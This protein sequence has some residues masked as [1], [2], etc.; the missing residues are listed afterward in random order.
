VR[1]LIAPDKF[2]GTATAVEAAE[3][4]ALGAL[5][6]GWQPVTIPLADGG[7]GTL[8]AFGGATETSL[9]TGPLGRPVEA[10]WRLDGEV[11]VVEMAR[12][13]GLLLAGGAEHNDPLAATSRGTGELI[14]EAVHRG[15]RRVVVGVG[16]S[17]CTD[18]GQGAAEVLA[19][20]APLDGS[21]GHLV[22]VAYDVACRFLDAPQRFGPQKGATPAE[23]ELLTDRLRT[24]AGTYRTRY[25]VD[26]LDL[27][28]SGAAGGLGGGL[29]AL[30]A[31]LE[32]GFALIADAVGL[33]PAM[34]G[35]DLVLTGE[36]LLDAQSF[37]GKVVG[38]VAA[39]ADEAGLPWCA[40]VGQAAERPP[41]T[42]VTD[43]VA[44]FGREAALTS[45]AQCLRI[46]ARDLLQAH[47]DRLP[48][49]PAAPVRRVT[50]DSQAGD[51]S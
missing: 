19:D 6:A 22:Q 48:S 25:G 14:A 32:P 41:G 33:R 13:S 23:V 1:I 30:G 29:A 37:D 44:T 24:L 47:A 21:R 4:L 38:G 43:L 8:E 34:R 17:A 11:A 39:A 16:G 9:V 45:T 42:V 27:P 12:A 51:A 3:A 28:G 26:V 20:L 49:S 31:A 2:R 18:G 50:S 40:V 35:V 36:G 15:A 46:A 7:E 5:D 10:A